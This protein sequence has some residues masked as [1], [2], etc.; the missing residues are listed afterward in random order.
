[1]LAD[2]RPDNANAAADVL[3]SAGYDV[4]VATVDSSSRSAV[5]ALVDTAAR[6]CTRGFLTT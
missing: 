6:S 2:M 3:A 4:S 5:H 1:M